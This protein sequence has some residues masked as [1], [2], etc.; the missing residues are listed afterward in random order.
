MHPR[1]HHPRQP[2]PVSS[3]QTST[4]SY[5]DP[6][7]QR[8]D[9]R[10]RKTRSVQPI[11]IS[12]SYGS[13]HGHGYSLSAVHAPTATSELAWSIPPTGGPNT[14]PALLTVPS[15]DPS[16]SRSRS[17]SRSRS[18]QQHPTYAFP[19]PMAPSSGSP[20]SATVRY[21]QYSP[22]S[23]H[24]LH[25]PP[26]QHHH[27]VGHRK[28][29]SDSGHAYAVSSQSHSGRKKIHSAMRKEGPAFDEWRA[30]RRTRQ[31]IG[32][33]AV[34]S[35]KLVGALLIFNRSLH[36]SILCPSLWHRRGCWRIASRCLIR[37]C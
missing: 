9:E 34:R 22:S 17:H 32:F 28:S 36:S 19:A 4:Y 16:R 31:R 6:G 3:Y 37:H 20:A 11:T 12:P 1:Q 15:R 35:L 27:A 10:G 8:H 33:A 18:Q 23:A 2:S 14:A 29:H 7:S 25:P 5:V 21:H 30:K 13:S 24:T 26:P